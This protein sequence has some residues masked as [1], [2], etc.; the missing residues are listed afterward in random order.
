MRFAVSSSVSGDRN[1]TFVFHNSDCSITVGDFYAIQAQIVQGS[2]HQGMISRKLTRFQPAVSLY[3]CPRLLA[4]RCPFLK[5]SISSPSLRNIAIIGHPRFTAFLA[6]NSLP[7]P[8]FYCTAAIVCL[9][10]QPVDQTKGWL[11][12]KPYWY[13]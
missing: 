10:S 5:S 4:N 1:L 7:E 2:A 6:R 12:H 13:L 9:V 11:L 3:C 8:H